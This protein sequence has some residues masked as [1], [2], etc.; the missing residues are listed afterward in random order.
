MYALKKIGKNTPKWVFR[1][2][3]LYDPPLPRGLTML[4]TPVAY[5]VKFKF[6]LNL[7]TG[8]ELGNFQQSKAGPGLSEETLQ[9]PKGDFR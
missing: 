7:P 5:R 6:K 3:G 2:A 4:K 8:T 1:A 9:S